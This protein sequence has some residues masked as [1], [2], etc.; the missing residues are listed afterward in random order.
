MRRLKAAVIGV[1]FIGEAHVEAIRRVPYVDVV[2][3]VDGF[4]AKEKAQKL[5]VENCFADYKEM[6]EVCEPDCIH[7]CTPNHT[8]MEIA[9]YAFEHGIHVICEKPM[10]M[11]AKEA[12]VMLKAAKASGLVN[13]LN[14]HN[15]YYPATHNLRNMVRAGELG[16]IFSVQGGYLQDWLLFD[17]DFSWK[18]MSQ[19]VGKTRAVADIG[20]HWIDLCEYVIGHK[21][22]EVFAE[23]K[24]VHPTR[25]QKTANGY[26]EIEVDTEDLAYI[27]LRFDNDVIASGAISTVFSGKKNQTTLLVSGAKMSVEWDNEKLENLQMGYRDRPN[28]VWSKNRDMAD[29]NTAPI[30]SYPAGHMEGFSDAF[31]QNFTAIYDAIRGK[32]PANPF[33]TFEDGL[34]LM[35]ICDKLFESSRSRQWE[36]V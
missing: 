12:E 9:L 28:S 36:K 10:A 19:Q 8:H 20:S 27:L 22:V 5:D 13:A 33:A 32:E 2:A 3:I 4:N 1:G 11:N 18:V 34:H 30:I 35:K 24:K 25:K 23:F 15:R 6:I 16:E 17:T 14:F 29:A 7:V 26:E 21:V 31:K